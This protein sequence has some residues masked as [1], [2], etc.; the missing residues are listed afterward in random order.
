MKLWLNV[1]EGAE[2]AASVATRSTRHANAES[3]GTGVSVGDERSS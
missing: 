2:Y 3:F 1:R